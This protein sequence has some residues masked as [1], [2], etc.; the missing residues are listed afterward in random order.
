MNRPIIRDAV[1]VQSSSNVCKG[2][3]SAPRASKRRPLTMAPFA[4]RPALAPTPL[5]SQPRNYLRRRFTQLS[6]DLEAGRHRAAA[7]R[8]LSHDLLVQPD[9]HFRR[10]VERAR[11]AEQVMA[12]LAEGGGTV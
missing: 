12:K 7:F 9:V 8:E 6:G 2:A 11:I 4:P 3:N 1:I 5:R 10:A